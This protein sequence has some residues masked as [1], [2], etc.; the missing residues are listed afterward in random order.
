MP[1]KNDEPGEPG[2]GVH[3]LNPRE[4]DCLLLVAAGKNSKQIGRELDVPHLTV[5]DRIKSACRK[6]SASNR[7]HAAQIYMAEIYGVKT[8]GSSGTPILGP[9]FR[10]IP[11][12]A[13]PGDKGASAGESDGSDEYDRDR[14][15]RLVSLGD[16][17]RGKVRP[18]DSYP[19]ATFFWGTNK[20]SA[21]RRILI[22]LAIALGFV[23]AVG[24]VINGMSALAR[25]LEAPKGTVSKGAGR[26]EYQNMLKERL[27][28]A[29]M[30]ATELAEAEA[31]VDNAIAKIGS[32][33]NALPASQ[34]AVNLSPVVGDTAYAHIQD[35][36]ASILTGRSKL[37]AFHHELD[38]IKNNH[39]GLRNFRITATGDAVKILEPQGLN[40]DAATAS[41]EAQ[42]A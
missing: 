17:R 30:V 25:L 26:G 1:R 22:S 3:R 10:G 18:K 12:G 16:S 11:N 31:A 14:V 41:D 38:R 8:D 9:E 20:L 21:G 4:R 7:T 39:A 27:A 24:T 37:V 2:S 28:A 5:D 13:R 19:F 34:A 36:F 23:V 15:R 33:V 42:A 35:V 40:D 32:L 6:L 29:N